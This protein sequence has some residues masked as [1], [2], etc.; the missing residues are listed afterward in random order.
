M[1]RLQSIASLIL[2]LTLSKSALAEQTASTRTKLKLGQTQLAQGLPADAM[3]SFEAVLAVQ[4]SNIAAKT[5]EVQAAIQQALSQRQSGAR[6]G[7][8]ATLAR[9][10]NFVPDDPTLLMDFGIQADSMRIYRD[11]EAALEQA[12][13]LAPDDP[14]ILY[15]LAHVELDEQKMP[16]AE[17]DLR[18]YLKMRPNDASAHY[19]LGHLLHMMVKDDEAKLEFE[20]S[21]HLQPQQTESWYQLGEI[22]LSRHEYAKARTDYEKVLQRDP[23][24]G[25]ALTGMGV[26]AYRTKDYSS[27]ERYLAQAVADAPDYPAAHRFYAMLLARQGKNLQADKEEDLARTLTERQDKL[28]HGYVLLATPQTQ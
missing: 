3:K 7:A 11:A 22:A 15:G 4:P 10:K 17:A 1:S 24:H 27:A 19:G 26:L 14:K 18:A 6:D 9:A 13:K 2:V 21:L 12:H 8:L 16:Q 20:R 23:R 28:Q 25:G 5:G